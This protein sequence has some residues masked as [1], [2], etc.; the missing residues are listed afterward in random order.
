MKKSIIFS[1]CF[2]LTTLSFA[3]SDVVIDLVKQG[4]EYH[5]K[6]EFDQAIETYKRALKIEPN[7]TLVHYE[8]ALSYSEIGNHKNAIKHCNFVIKQKQDHLIHAYVVK[9][10]SLDDLGKSK[11]AIKVYKE[12]IE[13]EGDHYLLYYNL[14]LTYFRL[15]DFK[16][17]EPAILSAINNNYNHPS[18]HLMMAKLY[19][20]K[21]K[22]VQSLLS[23]HFFL[24]LEPNSRR[25]KEAYAMLMD[26]FGGNVSKDKDEPNTINI[27]VNISDDTQFA[28]TEL[29]ISLLETKATLE[30]YKDKSKEDLFIENTQSFFKMLGGLKKEGNTGIWWDFYIPFFDDIAQS[31][32]ID[33]FCHFISQSSNE[34]SIKWLQEN[35]EK[36]TAFSEWL[37]GD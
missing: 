11:K 3:Q 17:A 18:S 33:T 26:N 20:L 29:M 32:H 12:G 30:E 31:D 37:S 13:T 35:E 4:I 22:P 21:E 6:G 7:S 25:S 36:I 9:G 15:Q 8:L 27:N 19:H 10:S 23:S 14:G 24:L 2:F 34:N 5:D 28:A 1:L 16:N